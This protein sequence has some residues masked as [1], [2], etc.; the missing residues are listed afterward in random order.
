MSIYFLVL[1][2]YLCSTNLLIFLFCPFCI[3]LGQVPFIL[4]LHSFTSFLQAAF[5]K[6]LLIKQIIS[7]GKIWKSRGDTSFM[8]SEH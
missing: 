3:S 8:V 6:T 4:L 2:S 1:F 5:R 7:E